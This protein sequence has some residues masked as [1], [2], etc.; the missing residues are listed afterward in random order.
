[1]KVIV[2]GYN[3]TEDGHGPEVISASYART[4]RDPREIPEIR[5]D[6]K[7][8]V[9]KARQSNK[10][11]VFGVGHSSIAEHAMFNIDIIGVSR[12]LVEEI[13]SHR[14]VAYTE[15][16]QRYV[17]F[18]GDYYI[19][20]ELDD[21][22]NLK[23]SYRELANKQFKFYETVYPK[24]LE[25]F[26]INNPEKYEKDPKTV[27]GWAKED[28]RYAIPISTKTQLGMTISARNLELMIRRLRAIDSDEAAILASKLHDEVKK[29]APSLFPYTT[30]SPLESKM[31]NV[32]IHSYYNF[33]NISNQ[34]SFV[35][36][37]NEFDR[38]DKLSKLFGYGPSSTQY[39][40]IIL[41]ILRNM[42]VFDAAPRQFEFVDF[43][44]L[45]NMSFSCFAQ[46]KRHRMMSIIPYN[47]TYA[48]YFVVPD[49]I[50]YSNRESFRYLMEETNNFYNKLP[51]NIKN[52]ILTNAHTRNVS[53]KLNLREMYHFCRMRMD[54]HA[55]WEIR[56]IANEM[57]HYASKVCPIGMSLCCGKD[58]FEKVYKEL[59]D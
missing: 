20:H 11:I 14:L 59:F 46:L 38:D 47:P 42:K 13:E 43:E 16:S 18:D 17:L 28:A 2:A 54:S 27:E 4:S 24:L 29:I 7:K 40:F 55:Q 56:S 39:K 9:E 37:N 50:S 32:D 3:K 48:N 25:Y 35:D 8:D 44:F 33:N 31:K 21:F 22:P 12:Y 49:S 6:A 30:P 15:K 45:L 41:K 19:P 23:E 52:Y 51:E 26:K 36:D 10:N 57:K 5:E 53:V 58:Q 1:M 34:V